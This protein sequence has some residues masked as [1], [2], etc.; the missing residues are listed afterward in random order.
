MGDSSDA[1]P[2]AAP[3]PAPSRPLSRL[4][5]LLLA[6]ALAV[7][8]ACVFYQVFGRY[9]LGRAP[10]WTEEL[11][12]YLLVWMT[13]LG[14]AAGIARGE[15][16]TVT[17]LTDRLGDRARRWV[18]ALR[19]AVI[20]ATAGVLAWSGLAYARLNGAQESAAIEM[21]MTVPY[22][23]VPAGGALIV[24]IVVVARLRGRPVALSEGEAW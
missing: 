17:V 24:L 8:A 7:M 1:P 3:G 19:D 12:R 18:V 6:G 13:M 5:S 9:V 10:A 23:A 11:A 14:S 21:P 22:L 2:P 4:L 16:I 15:H 20:V